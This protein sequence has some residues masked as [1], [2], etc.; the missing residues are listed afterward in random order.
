MT[1]SEAQKRGKTPLAR[2][3]SWAQAGVDPKIMG[4]GPIPASRA[5]LKKAGWNAA[6]WISSKPTKRLP[7]RPAP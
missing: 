5:A 4:T 1:A 7:R 2:I 6:T 3:V